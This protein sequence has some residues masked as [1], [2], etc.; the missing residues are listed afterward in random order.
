M[1]NHGRYRM[2]KRLGLGKHAT[3][4][5]LARARERGRATTEF[6]GSFRAYLNA[7]SYVHRASALIYG[8]NIYWLGRDDVLVTV[9]QVPA[10]YRKY[11]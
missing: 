8:Q 9:Y 11:L 2:R 10:K 3:D 4:R 6:R 1:T 5:A 7:Q